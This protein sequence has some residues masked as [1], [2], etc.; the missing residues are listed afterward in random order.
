MSE[1]DKQEIRQR[2]KQY[3]KD[4]PDYQGEYYKNHPA[5]YRFIAEE[6]LGR[7]L[8]DSEIVHHIDMD[9]TNN[10]KENLYIYDGRSKHLIGHGSLNKLTK[11]LLN[12]RIIKFNDG[13]Y[14]LK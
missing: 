11:Y 4:H 7:K 2:S 12:N 6:K 10:D 1:S 13:I 14:D 8:K 3:R 9:G 5:I